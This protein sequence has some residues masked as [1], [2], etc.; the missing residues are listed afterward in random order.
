MDEVGADRVEIVCGLTS[1]TLAGIGSD[2]GIPAGGAAV[3]AQGGRFKFGI[4]L[5]LTPGH[6][7][8]DPFNTAKPITWILGPGRYTTGV[9]LRVGRGL[10]QHLL[11][12]GTNNTGITASAGFP[13]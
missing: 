8:S 5:A 2:A 1:R 12:Q 6:F 4:I 9:P 11:G 7:A 13:K 10:G 3:L